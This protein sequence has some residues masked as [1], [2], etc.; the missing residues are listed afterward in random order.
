M[1]KKKKTTQIKI[2]SYIASRKPNKSSFKETNPF[3][4]N[5]CAAGQQMAWNWHGPIGNRPSIIHPFTASRWAAIHK[6]Q[7]QEMERSG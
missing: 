4:L 3:S 2:C 1:F 7:A 6:R 5:S